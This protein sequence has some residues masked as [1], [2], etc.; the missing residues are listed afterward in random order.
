MVYEPSAIL[1]AAP[2][3]FLLVNSPARFHTAHWDATLSYCSRYIGRTTLQTTHPRRYTATATELEADHLTK[4][5]SVSVGACSILCLLP[6]QN[7]AN[8]YA[9]NSIHRGLCANTNDKLCFP[10]PSV[11]I[12]PRPHSRVNDVDAACWRCLPL[13]FSPSFLLPATPCLGTLASLHKT[14]RP[15]KQMES[16]SPMRSIQ[17]QSLSSWTI[18]S[19][20]SKLSSC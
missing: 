2:F 19:A 18:P 14:A 20:N 6:N 5:R 4:V 11:T 16:V 7:Q 9:A 15:R 17:W 10:A 13:L 12:L 3:V 8:A 1:R